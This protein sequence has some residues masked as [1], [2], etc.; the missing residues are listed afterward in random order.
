MMYN[1]DMA[2]DMKDIEK[3]LL[4]DKILVNMLK[5]MYDI[6]D[7]D[8]CFENYMMYI[9]MIVIHYMLNNANHTIDI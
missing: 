5:H 2:Q 6:E 9:E 4:R 7:E 1:S 3:D 8:I